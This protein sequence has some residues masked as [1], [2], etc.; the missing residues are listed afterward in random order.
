MVDASLLRRDD[1][2]HPRDAVMVEAVTRV[3]L[4]RVATEQEWPIAERKPAVVVV[5][6]KKCFH[7]PTL[8]FAAVVMLR[9][10]LRFVICVGPALG[11]GFEP[12]RQP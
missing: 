2:L 3:F 9:R 10:L 4:L 6:L 1:R 7:S 11:S 5:K 8:L 12:W